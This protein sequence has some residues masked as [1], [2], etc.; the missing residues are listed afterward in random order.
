MYDY[1]RY[2][3]GAIIYEDRHRSPYTL[4]YIVEISYN[5]RDAETGERIAH[6]FPFVFKTCMD[7]FNFALEQ[8]EED[9][10]GDDVSIR[11][12]MGSLPYISVD[13]N[14][15]FGTIATYNVW[16]YTQQEE[17]LYHLLSK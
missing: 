7:A 2:I 3:E 5:R 8:A 11:L 12:E 10:R 4:G 17:M 6:T 1:D 13:S 14:V 15:Y 16:K 9:Y